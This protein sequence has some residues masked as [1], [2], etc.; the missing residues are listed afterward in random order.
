MPY[1]KIQYIIENL[2]SV[3]SKACFLSIEGHLKHPDSD[4]GDFEKY[5]GDELTTS[6]EAEGMDE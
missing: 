2:L 4:S 5:F 1:L 6:L 3:L